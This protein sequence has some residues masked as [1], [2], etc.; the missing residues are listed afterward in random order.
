MIDVPQIEFDAP[1]HELD[2]LRLAAESVHLRPTRDPGPH[3]MA[4]GIVTDVA[5]VLVVMSERVRPRTYNRHLAFEHIEELRQFVDAGTT[6]D[7]PK[8]RHT[9]I[10]SGC[11]ELRMLGMM[12]SR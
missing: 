8:H 2:S 1:R 5:L 12:V 9:M 6:Q 10:I 11:H 7:A 3:V 4:E